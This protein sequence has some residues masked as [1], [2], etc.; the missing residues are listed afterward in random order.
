MK[1]SFATVCIG[2]LFAGAAFL[3]LNDP[4]PVQW[5]LMYIIAAVL[6]FVPIMRASISWPHI[7]LALVC[8]VWAITILPSVFNEAAFIGTEEEREV[9]GLLLVAVWMG[10]LFR[11]QRVKKGDQIAG[12]A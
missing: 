12:A 7:V 2:V 8:F 11:H 9:A 5:F 6:S 3:Q 4:D 1:F 10:F